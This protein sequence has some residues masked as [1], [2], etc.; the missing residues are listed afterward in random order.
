MAR[1]NPLRE[2]RKIKTTALIRQET[3]ST[4]SLQRDNQPFMTRLSLKLEEWTLMPIPKLALQELSLTLRVE[5]RAQK[6]AIAQ[7]QSLKH[8]KMLGQRLMKTSLRE[9]RFWQWLI[10]ITQVMASIAECTW[11]I[12]STLDSMAAME[13]LVDILGVVHMEAYMEVMAAMVDIL[14]AELMEVY[15]EDMELLEDSMEAMVDMVAMEDM[16]TQECT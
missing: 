2:K 5:E 8:I 9:I 15:M 11:I 1:S 3:P 13:V 6:E 12:L 14:G 4:R 16:V 10:H 7:D